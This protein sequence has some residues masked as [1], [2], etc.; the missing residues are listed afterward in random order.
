MKQFPTR[1]RPTLA[2]GSATVIRKESEVRK[3]IYNIYITDVSGSMLDCV[4]YIN[5]DGEET[6]S[7]PKIE[8]LNRGLNDALDSMRDFEKTHVQY[9]FMMQVIELNSYGKA[10]F[11]EGFVPVSEVDRVS[12]EAHGATC[13]ENSLTTLMKYLTKRY[14]QTN[15]KIN[16]F[17]MSDGEPTDVNGNRIGEKGYTAIIDRF[18]AHLKEYGYAGYIDLY[19]I[20]VS[21]ADEKMLRYFADEGRFYRVGESESLASWISFVTRQSFALGTGGPLMLDPRTGAPRPAEPSLPSRPSYPPVTPHRVMIDAGRM[22]ECMG[23]YICLDACPQGAIRPCNG[24]VS[25]D[26]GLCDG[27]GICRSVCPKGVIVDATPDP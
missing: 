6:F 12:L 10:I 2:P 11:E 16:V 4:K 7:P 17:L 21:G 5:A 18:K 3:P 27:C 22:A 14:I 1:G 15:R 23:C 25:V 19:A 8:E 24:F 9:R 26:D 13:L 20:A